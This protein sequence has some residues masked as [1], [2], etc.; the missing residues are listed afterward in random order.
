VF[1]LY[2]MGYGLARLFVEGFRQA[3]AQFVTTGNPYGH[4]LRLGAESGLT[5]GQ[6]LTLPMLAVG[7][8]L[9]LRAARSRPA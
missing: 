7:L 2:L 6:L 8:F 3:D 1:A 4:V 5:M 9:L